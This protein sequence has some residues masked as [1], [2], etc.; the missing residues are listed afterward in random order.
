MR[1][2]VT[3]TGNVW[4]H[5]NPYL[6]QFKDIV[7]VV[8]LNG[9][10]ATDKYECFVSPYKQVG[11]GID[12]Y[13]DE[14]NR[15]K[16]L[17][18]V[19]GKLNARLHYHEDVVFLADDEPSTLYPFYAIKKLNEY[20][21]FHLVTMSPWAFEGNRRIAAYNGMLED[22]SDLSSLL[23]YDSSEVFTELGKKTTLPEAFEYVKNYFGEIMPTFLNGINKMHDGPCFFDFSTMKYVPLENGFSKIKTGK[24]KKL[25]KKLEFEVYRG[26][27][28]LG[29]VCP[30]SYPEEDEY[31][32]KEVERPAARL[33]GKKI[34]N[35]LREQRILL[36]EANG[37]PFESEV[38]PSIG[39]CAGTCEKCDMES[40]YLR[41]QLQK[42]PEEKRVYPQ[43]DPKKEVQP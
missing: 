3:D 5:E 13:G 4:N 27:S 34:C 20:N 11:M 25:D 9:K 18:S 39:P 2:V 31:T 41:K 16:A 32:K 24:K 23:Y 35:V 42:I 19:A 6:E 15:F 40:K 10:E 14:D 22:L 29:I 28:T 33:D 26:F 36:A 7:I 30:P 1:I 37:I 43:F 17:A 12:K 21:S 38:C 8:C